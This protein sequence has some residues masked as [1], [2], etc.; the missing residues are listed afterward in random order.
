MA[1]TG[2]YLHRPAR[3]R[4]DITTWTNQHVFKITQKNDNKLYLIESYE[5]DIH[6]RAGANGVRECNFWYYYD[7]WKKAEIKS[8][9]KNGTHINSKNISDG[10]REEKGKY[11]KYK[12]IFGDGIIGTKLKV[13]MKSHTVGHSYASNWHVKINYVENPKLEIQSFSKVDIVVELWSHHHHQ[14]WDKTKQYVENINRGHK[15]GIAYRLLTKT[16]ILENKNILAQTGDNWVA[17]YS[18]DS[19]GNLVKDWIQI[20]RDPRPHFYGKSHTFQGGVYPPWDTNNVHGFRKHMA[21]TKVTQDKR[22][23]I[24]NGY[25]DANGVVLINYVKE[26]FASIK[27][28]DALTVGAY[29]A[30][31]NTWAV[32]RFSK[33]VSGYFSNWILYKKD[34]GHLKMLR[35]GLKKENNTIKLIPLEPNPARYNT[36]AW[37]GNI[38]ISETNIETYWNK[39]DTR[40]K[41]NWANIDIQG[42]YGMRYV[43]FYYDNRYDNISNDIT[44]N[45]LFTIVNNNTNYKLNFKNNYNVAVTSNK[46]YNGRSKRGVGPWTNYKDALNWCINNNWRGFHHYDGKYYVTDDTKIVSES[47]FTLYEIKHVKYDTSPKIPDSSTQNNKWATYT[48]EFSKKVSTE[49]IKIQMLPQRNNHRYASNWNT[50][51]N[52]VDNKNRYL[53]TQL[54]PNKKPIVKWKINGIEQKSHDIYTKNI[55]SHKVDMTQ[56]NHIYFEFDYENSISMD[57]VRWLSYN[58]NLLYNTD[59]YLDEIR[60]F[61]EPL[62]DIEIDEIVSNKVIKETGMQEKG[63]YKF[64]NNLKQYSNLIKNHTLTDLPLYI[65][66]DGFK[67]DGIVQH[68]F[69]SY[70]TFNYLYQDKIYSFFEFENY[71]GAFVHYLDLNNNKWVKTDI[72]LPNKFFINKSNTV[73]AH[74]HM[75]HTNLIYDNKIIIFTSETRKWPRYKRGSEILIID[76]KENTSNIVKPLNDNLIEGTDIPEGRYGAGT[77]VHDKYLWVF[78]GNAGRSTG[79]RDLNDIWKFNLETYKWEKIIPKSSSNPSARRLPSYT[80]YNNKFYMFGGDGN[81]LFNELWSFDIN[82][83]LWNKVHNGSGYCPSKRYES[84]GVLF[85]NTFIITGGDNNADEL[86]GYN[87][88]NNFWLKYPINTKHPPVWG[89]NL[90]VNKNKLYMIGGVY[91]RS[92]TYNRSALKKISVLDINTSNEIITI[93]ESSPLFNLFQHTVNK[94]SF[95]SDNPYLWGPIGSSPNRFVYLQKNQ[96]FKNKLRST[97]YDFKTKI[98]K[99]LKDLDT[100][101]NIIYDNYNENDELKSIL[102]NKFNENNMNIDKDKINFKNLSVVDDK[103]FAVG[104]IKISNGNNHS[105]LYYKETKDS[106]WKNISKLDNK[107]VR[108]VRITNTTGTTGKDPNKEYNY[109][110]IREIQVFDENNVNVARNGK[111]KFVPNATYLSAGKNAVA[112]IAIDG[113][114]PPNDSNWPDVAHTAN[115]TKGDYFELDLQKNYIINKIVVYNRTFKPHRMQKHSL[116]LFDEKYNEIT[117]YSRIL[118]N[119]V[120]QS[121]YFANNVKNVSVSKYNNKLWIAY[122]NGED[123]MLK[124][125]IDGNPQILINQYQPKLWSKRAY[126]NDL[127]NRKYKN[128]NTNHYTPFKINKIILKYPKIYVNYNYNGIIRYATKDKFI[129]YSE[130]ARNLDSYKL[131]YFFKNTKEYYSCMVTPKSNR[132]GLKLANTFD[133]DINEESGNILT[134]A[135]TYIVNIKPIVE[136]QITY[137]DITSLEKA[138]LQNTLTNWENIE[139]HQ[140][141]NIIKYIATEKEHVWLVTNTHNLYFKSGDISQ[142]KNKKS[143]IQNIRAITVNNKDSIMEIIYLSNGGN[144][145]WGLLNGDIYHR[146]GPTPNDG[147][148]EK[149]INIDIASNINFSNWNS[150]IVNNNYFDLEDIANNKLPRLLKDATKEYLWINYENYNNINDSTLFLTTEIPK[151]AGFNSKNEKVINID[152]N[153]PNRT[154]DIVKLF[155]DDRRTDINNLIIDQTPTLRNETGTLGE[156]IVNKNPNNIKTK[157]LG[158][159]GS[160]SYDLTVRVRSCRRCSNPG[161]I[162]YSK[163]NKI[164]DKTNG[165][166]VN[167]TKLRYVDNQWKYIERKHVYTYWPPSQGRIASNFVDT[168]KTG[169]MIIITMSDDMKK[170]Y[171]EDKNR[172]A[173]LKK[174]F[175]SKKILDVGF[176]QGY[177][178]ISIKGFDTPIY[179]E[180]GTIDKFI[181]IW[182]ES[183][184]I[185]INYTFNSL[186][187]DNNANIIYKQQGIVNLSRN[188]EQKNNFI[189]KS[190]FSFSFL[191]KPTT[192]N[193]NLQKSD[194]NI[195]RIKKTNND[196][197]FFVHQ[198]PKNKLQIGWDND[199]NKKWWTFNKEFNKDKCY[200]I[201]IQIQKNS[202]YLFVNG[203]LEQVISIVGYLTVEHTNCTLYLSGEY[204]DP[205]DCVI[206]D[207]LL[208]NVIESD[209]EKAKKNYILGL[210]ILMQV[211]LNL[212]IIY[213]HI[214]QNL[215]LVP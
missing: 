206:K 66:N 112:S 58:G 209:N 161:Q 88:N 43:R 97:E 183:S 27:I 195:I 62:T 15:N 85:N 123:L 100:N 174:H 18:Q 128:K 170:R 51:V 180:I 153:S 90:L 104:E 114:I 165:G 172:I 87:L 37:K 199:T 67:S 47:K 148:W 133:F 98:I 198:R 3:P 204:T 42:G 68:T 124:E 134:L 167:I 78:Y 210:V 107:K 72:K 33:E 152:T 101:N 214:L 130:N 149:I 102:D 89:G 201:K 69:N 83:L 108:Y 84:T 25:V 44:E 81:G 127:Y 191:Y 120:S 125:G 5:V 138:V 111:A 54:V 142:L 193:L 76:L 200:K 52:L 145:V 105:N 184:N 187:I 92:G 75:S 155:N 173:N 9:L 57:I 215:N 64:K 94:N 185:K 50:S 139:K 179:E 163:K 34:G 63:W 77:F 55:Y 157:I 205:A 190:D 162:I 126:Y 213:M 118:S 53:L 29:L 28:I 144:N 103:I 154:I 10:R 35:I 70:Y 160:L 122:S 56:W 99:T 186:K 12:I 194:R 171:S 24:F 131:K 164:L 197:V 188:N 6:P 109:I 1:N 39:S 48:Y 136:N 30:R 132:I 117:Q 46:A 45:S 119:L 74:N 166:G 121:Y 181:G 61:K 168:F 17:G 4:V 31:G 93:P 91:N 79:Y 73:L 156:L 23:H 2:R 80:F 22:I 96:Y 113:N 106:Y 14:S 176:R 71:F 159:F 147:S 182:W 196:S 211:G 16:E 115:A 95:N 40:K 59:S 129:L 150:K 140:Y 36:G 26:N 189:L 158:G 202:L 13:Q 151:F 11:N 135:R 19:N 60:F 146:T 169:E 20:G 137:T 143:L 82:T 207:V 203:I 49:K 86:W 178:L 192:H 141:G 110:Q 208:E 38:A 116:T 7:G 212:K 32:H 21:V 177:V 175:G 8:I 41:N 65:I